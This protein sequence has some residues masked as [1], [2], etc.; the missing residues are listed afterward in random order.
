MTLLGGIACV[1]FLVLSAGMVF[2]V[3]ID[4]RGVYVS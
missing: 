2:I 3:F 1:S 4:T